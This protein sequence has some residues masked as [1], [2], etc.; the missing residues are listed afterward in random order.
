M[1]VEVVQNEADG[2]GLGEMNIHQ[3]AQPVG[4]ILLFSVSGDSRRA[5]ASERLKDHEPVTSPLSDVLII[6]TRRLTRLH[7]QWVTTIRQ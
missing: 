4:E 5:P 3:I 7:R 6:V 1:R 2:I